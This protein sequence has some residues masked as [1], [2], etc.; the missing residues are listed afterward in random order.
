MM[1]YSVTKM[2]YNLSEV[3]LK[4]PRVSFTAWT[5]TQ[6]KQSLQ[7]KRSETRIVK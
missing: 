6:R 3:R 2:F 7:N 1:D 4:N 5:Y